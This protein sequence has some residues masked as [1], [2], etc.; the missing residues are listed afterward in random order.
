MSCVF[1]GGGMRGSIASHPGPKGN[2]ER[3]VCTS[4][5]VLVRDD[6]RPAMRTCGIDVYFGVCLRSV[7]SANRSVL[8]LTLG[9]QAGIV[10]VG[11]P[12]RLTCPDQWRSAEQSPAGY[13]PI[14]EYPPS[15]GVAR[16]KVEDFILRD[17][18]P[19]SR[20]AHTAPDTCCKTCQQHHRSPENWNVATALRVTP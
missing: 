14:W 1:C 15:R 7:G 16:Y 18:C 5:L 11:P 8:S 20:H 6:R 2:A 12:G 17:H 4:D 10:M 13:G 3:D 19:L 9:E